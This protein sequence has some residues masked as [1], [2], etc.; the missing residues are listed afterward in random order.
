MERRTGKTSTS[1]V[2]CEILGCEYEE[3]VIKLQEST[4]DGVTD[5]DIEHDNNNKVDGGAEGGEQEGE[6]E[7]KNKGK[8]KE[9]EEAEE[10]DEGGGEDEVEIDD[11]IEC[12]RVLDIN[13]KGI[14]SSIWVRA[15][16]MAIS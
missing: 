13:I 4:Q 16:H 8:G 3:E 10:E 12:C 6:N 14:E 1:T 5:I 7:G 15:E 2:P 9:K 11:H